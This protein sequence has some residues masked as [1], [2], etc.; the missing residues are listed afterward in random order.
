MT[1]NIRKVIAKKIE[2]FEQNYVKTSQPMDLVKEIGD[3]HMRII[4][5]S[6]FCLSK[7]NSFRLPF[8]KNGII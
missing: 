2:E 3:L 4:L 7:F 5:V 6:A 1:E 8:E